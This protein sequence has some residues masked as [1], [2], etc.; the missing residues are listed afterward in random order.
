MNTMI[1]NATQKRS[2][3]L[4]VYLAVLFAVTVSTSAAIF[5][6]SDEI[7]ALL[8]PPAPPPSQPT[9]AVARPMPGQPTITAAQATYLVR[10]SLKSLHDAFRTGNFTVFRDLAG[11]SLQARYSATQL[12]EHFETSAAEST[13][14]A[15]AIMAKPVL[16]AASAIPDSTMVRLDGYVASPSGLLNFS[17][18]LEPAKGRW[19]VADLKLNSTPFEVAEA[20]DVAV[21]ALPQ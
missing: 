4:K 11:P 12:F 5:V 14:L 2:N 21:G 7:V 17:L 8:S 18:I 13:D 20:S 19:A 6:R 15:N 10:A 3:T 16:T 1:K 9:M